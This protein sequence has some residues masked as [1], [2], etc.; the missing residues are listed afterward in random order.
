MKAFILSGGSGTKHL[1]PLGSQGSATHCWNTGTYG[2]EMS[3]K[4]NTHDR[5]DRIVNLVEKTERMIG[6]GKM[7]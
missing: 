4:M 6:L 7:V 1:P 2:L 5:V 3:T